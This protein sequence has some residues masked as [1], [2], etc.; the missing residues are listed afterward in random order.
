MI[1]LVFILLSFSSSLFLEE[2]IKS[3]SP[4]DF[5]FLFSSFSSSF[6][7]LLISIFSSILSAE[8]VFSSS[9]LL[10]FNSLFSSLFL[11]LLSIPS[12]FLF[13]SKF[14]SSFLF[15]NISSSFL[16]STLLSTLFSIF[17]I[18]FFSFEGFNFISGEKS[19]S[20]LRSKSKSVLGKFNIL[21]LTFSIWLSI[22]WIKLDIKSSL[23]LSIIFYSIFF[24]FNLKF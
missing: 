13:I 16:F 11:L 10:L 3:H 7:S 18:S 24:N 22:F 4:S 2:F 6:C 12:T 19:I 1:I 5:D 21:F 20:K 9:S 17:I 14:S 23:L 8:I 15:F